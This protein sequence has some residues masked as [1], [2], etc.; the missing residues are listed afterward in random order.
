M[1][2]PI[3][4]AAD[5]RCKGDLNLQMLVHAGENRRSETG[6]AFAATYANSA[7]AQRVR[8]RRN[9]A[10]AEFRSDSERA[11]RDGCPSR[12]LLSDI[13][14]LNMQAIRQ[15]TMMQAELVL[16]AN[17]AKLK[18]SCH[19][20]KSMSSNLALEYLKEKRGRKRLKTQKKMRICRSC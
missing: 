4:S 19:A 9:P 12:D 10:V 15:T 8:Q 6:Q 18:L 14:M 1:P 5:K 3:K 11:G 17:P 16:L 7:P 13:V 20:E 2:I